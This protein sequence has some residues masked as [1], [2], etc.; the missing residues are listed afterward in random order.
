MHVSLLT[1]VLILCLLLIFLSCH[2]RR[3]DSGAAVPQNP[4]PNAVPSGPEPAPA[5]VSVSVPEPPTVLLL[6]AGVIGLAAGA[7][8]R[9]RRR[10]KR[11][12]EAP[13]TPK[14]RGPTYAPR[15]PR[16]A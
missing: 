16:R 3:G 11:A 8:R 7:W 5:S 9:R 4:T 2:H 10:G 1:S 6:G 15:H 13:V 12:E 14:P